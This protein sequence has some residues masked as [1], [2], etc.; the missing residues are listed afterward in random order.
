[1]KLEPSS[2][3]AD[4]Y[5]WRYALPLVH[6][7]K[8]ELVLEQNL[9]RQMVQVFTG[10]KSFLPLHRQR[11]STEDN[12]PYSHSISQKFTTTNATLRRCLTRWS[13]V[14]IKDETVPLNHRKYSDDCWCWITY[15]LRAL[16]AT[17]QTQTMHWRKIKQFCTRRNTTLAEVS[18]HKANL[19]TVTQHN[20]NSAVHEADQRRT[21]KG[22]SIARRAGFL[23]LVSM[24]AS[25][26]YGWHRDSMSRSRST[27]DDER[28]FSCPIFC[29]A[30]TTRLQPS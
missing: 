26:S 22:T 21:V 1:M 17:Q 6:A 9:W 28:F 16:P 10:W 29:H 23:V 2:V 7:R 18:P 3:E 20:V 5:V 15:R 30:S 27:I 19:G 25:S 24:F 13:S 11:Q 4:V 14:V 8:E 12:V